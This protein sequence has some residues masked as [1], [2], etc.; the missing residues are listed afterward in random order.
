M[1][2][3]PWSTRSSRLVYQ[4]P[5][6]RV[7]E[8]IAEMPDGRTTLYGV[9]ECSDAVGAATFEIVLEESTNNINVYY[10]DTDFGTS[11][12]NAGADATASRCC[13]TA[14]TM[15]PRSAP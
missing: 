6:T 12:Y 1:P 13:S 15:A 5:W 14:P 9:V 11:S 3:K 10:Q 7:R 2:P 8:D 4:N